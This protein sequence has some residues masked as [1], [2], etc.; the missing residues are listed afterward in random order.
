MASDQGSKIGNVLL[1]RKVYRP[2]TETAVPPAASDAAAQIALQAA[3]TALLL[4]V[5][6]GAR[7]SGVFASVEVGPN[8]VEC[9]ALAS[10]AP[11]QFRFER[12]GET[13]WVALVMKDRWQSQSIE[14]DLINT[15]D[16]LED[17][18]AEEIGEMGFEGNAHTT[19]EHFRSE[20]KLFTFRSRVPVHLPKILA[21]AAAAREAEKTASQWLLGYEACFRRLGDM[22]GGDDE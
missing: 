15:G 13:F 5:A 3:T 16:K 11:A 21:D 20:D 14:A 19:C 7:K 6:E 17:L 12:E 1:F 4:A 8:R 18:I 9:Q 22:E 10:A 2:L